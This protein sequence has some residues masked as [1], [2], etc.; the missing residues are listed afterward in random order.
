M[1]NKV[2][3]LKIEGRNAVIEAFRSGKPI[4]KLFLLDGCQ[5]GPI[6]TILREAKKGDTIINFVSK[7]RLDQLSETGKH[8]GAI[9]YVAAYEDELAHVRLCYNLDSVGTILGENN[10]DIAGSDVLKPYMAAIK[11]V[12]KDIFVVLRTA[13][14]SASELQDLLAGSRLVHMAAADH[15]NRYGA[16]RF[17]YGSDY[18]MWHVG[19]EIKTLL[20]LGLS[21]TALKKIFSENIL[22]IL[23]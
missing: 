11:S 16:E 21:D 15:V 9:A 1:E 7:D 10:I 2:E 19:D 12:N 8:Q 5:D 17:V 13:N 3:E 6:K 18:P 14:K 4:D 22:R 20:S 23:P